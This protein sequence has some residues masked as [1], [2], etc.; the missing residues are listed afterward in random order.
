MSKEC[1]LCLFLVN[2]DMLTDMALRQI[3]PNIINIDN[4]HHDA[5]GDSRSQN[6]YWVNLYFRA[7]NEL[8]FIDLIVD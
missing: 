4:V 5:P 6:C 8:L 2:L 3:T 1:V 7:N